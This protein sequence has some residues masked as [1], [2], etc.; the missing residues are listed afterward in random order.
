MTIINT[1][2][3]TKKNERQKNENK[4][5]KDIKIELIKNRINYVASL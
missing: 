3:H 1:F 5:K 2:V 4:R